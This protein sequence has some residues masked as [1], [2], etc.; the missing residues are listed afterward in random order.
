MMR[1][2]CPYD[3]EGRT[4]AQL[5]SLAICRRAVKGDVA[6]VRETCD[7]TEGKPM[8]SIAVSG[9][10]DMTITVEEIDKQINALCD[11]IRARGE[12]PAWTDTIQGA[13]PS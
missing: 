8:Q 2:A 3:A 4:W 7:R 13:E 5:I 10:L 9:G 6:A 1:S 11:K 12:A